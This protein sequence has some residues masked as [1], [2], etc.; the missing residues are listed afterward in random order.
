MAQQAQLFEDMESGIEPDL[1]ELAPSRDQ[2]LRVPALAFEMWVLNVATSDGQSAY[3]DQTIRQYRSMFNGFIRY[4]AEH[5]TTVLSAGPTVVHDFLTSLQ[6]RDPSEPGVAADLQKA[7]SRPAHRS[8]LKRHSDLIDEVMNHLVARGY[9]K[10]NPV[11]EAT[12]MLRGRQSGPRVVCMPTEIDARL[13]TYLLQDM[14]VSSWQAR[15]TRALLL[16]LAGGGVTASQASDAR[17]SQ[18]VFNDVVPSFDCAPDNEQEGYRAA[19]ARFCVE[20]LRDWVK[21]RENGIGPKNAEPDV[22][23]P[24]KNGQALSTVS[25]YKSVRNVLREIGFHGDDMGPRV[26][27]TTYARRQ[28]LAGATVEEVAGLLGIQN[29]RMVERLVRMTPTHTGYIPV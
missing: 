7:K 6:G 16:L 3:S 28:L 17:L 25:V 5:R 1:T 18:F 26:L 19:L 15:R 4:V 24:G 11:L 23:F 12:R 22:V 9:R 21:E 20:A 27:R 13:Q 10:I 8:T 2:W 29:T 14:D